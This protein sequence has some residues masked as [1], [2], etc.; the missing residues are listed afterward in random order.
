MSTCLTILLAPVLNNLT[1]LSFYMLVS[2]FAF[3]SL[4]IPQAHLASDF[5]NPTSLSASLLVY[6]VRLH[7][8]Q[9]GNENPGIEYIGLYQF[10]VKGWSSSVGLPDVCTFRGMEGGWQH[11]Q[12]GEL[13]ITGSW[14]DRGSGGGDRG[15]GG[16]WNSGDAGGWVGGLVGWVSVFTCGIYIACWIPCARWRLWWSV[17]AMDTV[18]VV[19]IG[20]VVVFVD[21]SLWEWGCQ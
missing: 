7:L 5:N 11:F 8:R 12:S 21:D 2:T 6:L 9:T 15:G 16:Y 18:V 1:C 4:P 13:W 17:C 19:A 3:T 14:Y 10:E 20:V